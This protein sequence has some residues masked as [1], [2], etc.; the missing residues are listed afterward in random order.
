MHLRHKMLCLAGATILAS[1]TFAQVP[2]GGSPQG[3]SSPQPTTPSTSAPPMTSGDLP[4]EAVNPLAADQKFLKDATE[5]ART[6]VEL[7]KL[8]QEK[9]SSDAVKEFGKRVVED[10]SKT[11]TDL[12][13]LAAKAGVS[14][15]S[16][17]PKKAKKAQ[18]KLSKLSG[19][20]FDRTFAKMM[21]NDHKSDAKS[22][23]K[24]SKNGKIPEAKQFASN[25]LPTVQERLKLAQELDE[26][27]KT[28]GKASKGDQ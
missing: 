1:G 16:D 17:M 24:E 18:E 20:D 13:Q 21:L 19:S 28:A 4:Q 26:T 27:V 25:S 23:E 6:Q 12:E 11:S 22:F 7:G 5:G 8:A 9:G 3:Q 15:E 14:V 2:G 10:H